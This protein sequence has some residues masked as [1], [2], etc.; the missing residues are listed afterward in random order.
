LQTSAA[1][2]VASVDLADDAHCQCLL[3]LLDHYALDPMGG[4]KGLSAHARAHLVAE[5]RRM[6]SYRGALAWRGEQAVG[7]VNCF[8]GL[9][10]FA[11]RPLLNIHDIVVRSD[12]RGQGVGQAL[13]GWAQDLATELRCC[14]LTLEVL[15]NNRRAMSLYEKAGFA[16][17]T[18]G[19][20]AGQAL[21]MQKLL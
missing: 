3:G 12:C 6:P 1:L 17:Y 13:L 7:L 11:A 14:K 4:G 8:T 16:P 2:R 20:A 18:L 19:P 10:T 9:S 15:S 21:L 5:L